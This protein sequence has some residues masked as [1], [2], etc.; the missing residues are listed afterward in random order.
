MAHPTLLIWALFFAAASWNIGEITLAVL[1]G[2]MAC[3][4]TAAGYRMCRRGHAV[5]PLLWAAGILAAILLLRRWAAVLSAAAVN[6]IAAVLYLAFA[7]AY[8]FYSAGV[9]EKTVGRHRQRRNI[10]AYLAR[11]LMA[12]KAYLCQHCGPGHGGRFV[13]GSSGEV[14]GMNMFPIGLAILC[15]N[16]P[17]CTLLSCDPDLEQAV[18]VLPGQ[19]GRFFINVFLLSFVINSIVACIY[20]C[21]LAVT[22]QQRRWLFP[23]D[24]ASSVCPAKRHTSGHSGMRKTSDP[25]LENRKRSVASVPTNISKFR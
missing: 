6:A 2:C 14:Q 23:W 3:A 18:R 22:H 24:N 15:L 5:L 12:N 9:A 10:F 11:Y 17:I 21:S 13:A 20:L 16:T 1:C 19:A 4:V 7:D 8:D 25:R